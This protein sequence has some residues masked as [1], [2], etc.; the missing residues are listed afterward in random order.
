MFRHSQSAVAGAVVLVTLFGGCSS[1]TTTETNVESVDA[2][3][4][5]K[6]EQVAAVRIDGDPLDSMPDSNEVVLDA[7]NDPMAGRVAPTL[8]GTAFDG[9]EVQIAPDGQAKAIYFVAHWCPH[10]QDEVPVV[11]SLIDQGAKPDGL[12]IYLVSTA[13][14]ESR[15]NYPVDR[16]LADEDISAAV[17]RD[18]ANNTALRSYGPSGFP[19]V[20]YLDAEHQVVARSRGSLSSEAIEQLWA[21]ALA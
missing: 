16:W 1:S 7:S 13:V 15:G 19:Y 21:L 20:V 5:E 9:I 11:Q 2:E 8:T 17:L 6:V 3:T 18:D 12:D 4:S 14:D 10:C